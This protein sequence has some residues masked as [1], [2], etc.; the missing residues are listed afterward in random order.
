MKRIYHP[1]DRWEEFTAGM[2]RVVSG[3]EKQ[4]FID[5]AATL[6]KNANEFKIQMTRALT[7]WPISCEVNLSS[8]S[9]NRQAWIGHAGCCLGVNS[10]ENCT[11]LGWHTLT[12]TEQDKANLAA[13]EVIELW[14]R[15][16]S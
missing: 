11:R 16:R 1:H 2:W 10:P 3:G 13:D 9:M 5:A 8:K 7:E 12:Q 14:E 4:K 6:M 15:G